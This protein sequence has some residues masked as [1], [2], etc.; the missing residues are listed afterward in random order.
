MRL[1]FWGKGVQD[2]SL[3]VRSG[4]HTGP[5][6]V[7]VCPDYADVWRVPV[8]HGWPA[9]GRLSRSGRWPAVGNRS[10]SAGQLHGGCRESDAGTGPVGV[11]Q[12]AL[13]AAFRSSSLNSRCFWVP[14]RRSFARTAR[15]RFVRDGVPDAR[16][17]SRCAWSAW[18][19][20]SAWP[21]RLCSTTA[22]WSI[23]EKL[24]VR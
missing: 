9:G 10:A 16:R 3:S 2:S 4:F 7:L 21:R 19:T 12:V 8:V 1:V 15:P 13:T 20:L 14:G 5:A 23:S 11:Q 18:A 6:R 17:L 24:V 22:P